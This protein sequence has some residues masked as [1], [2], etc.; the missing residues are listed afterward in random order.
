MP[1]KKRLDTSGA[2]SRFRSGE[3]DYGDA[4]HTTHYL[5]NDDYT[6]NEEDHP[7]TEEEKSF[8][9]QIAMGNGLTE[10]DL[11]EE[12]SHEKSSNDFPLYDANI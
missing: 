5:G 12:E 3:T 4:G 10:E 11:S 1:D 9:G 2:H 8:D 6:G 7:L